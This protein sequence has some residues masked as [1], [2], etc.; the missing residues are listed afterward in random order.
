MVRILGE[1]II[2]VQ[3]VFFDTQVFASLIGFF[4]RFPLESNP[5]VMNAYAERLGMDLS[6]FSFQDVLS[7][8]DWAL[9]MIPRRATIIIITVLIRIYVCT[10][11]IIN[12]FILHA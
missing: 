1:T 11:N 9:S 8:E 6:L 12:Y 3:K 4:L 10:T 2:L 7:T 5:E